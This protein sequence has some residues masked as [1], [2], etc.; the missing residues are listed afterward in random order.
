MSIASRGRAGTIAATAFISLALA[1]L[2]GPTSATASGSD[3]AE[4]AHGLELVATVPYED[5]THLERAS[6][7]GRDYVFA[8]TSSTST[9]AELR[10]IDVTVPTRPRV[11]ALINC[12]IFQGNL[13]V[14]PDRKTL[15]LGVDAAAPGDACIPPGE[16][17]FITIDISRPARPRPIGYAVIDGGSHST[18][19]HPR[20]PLVY[21][22]P[23]G[24][25]APARTPPELEV[26]SIANPAKPKLVNTISMPGANSPHDIS[27]NKDGSRAATANISSFHLLDT[28][29]PKNPAVEF[30]GQCPGCQ[31]THEARF[32]AGDKTL[33][34]NDEAIP[35]PYPCPGG[36]LY[37]YDLGGPRGARTADLAG[38]Y[39][40][41][42][43]GVTASESAGF[44]TPHVFDISRD[45]TKVAASWHA[46]GVRYLDISKHAGVTHGDQP[47]GPDGVIELGAYT[48]EGGDNFTAKF[49]KGPYI[50]SVDVNAGLQ[51]FRIA[52]V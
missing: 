41:S 35:S 27:F 29:D 47:S 43:A 1:A 9:A 32:T 17:G 48:V 8:A 21:N 28:S 5:G 38:A 14:S 13:Q 46:A 30:T 24:S 18:A 36:A 40:V 44:C 39:T 11:V 49:F 12:G 26:W 10:V 52:P 6:I 7:K 50:Y 42:D 23:E 19:V 15:I 4:V 25:P 51:I 20:K 33:V 16:Q 31:H 22:A 37:F 2:S 45:G 34:V 3:A